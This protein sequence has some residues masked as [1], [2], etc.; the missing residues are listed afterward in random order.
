MAKPLERVP[1][2]LY[3]FGNASKPRPPR[4]QGHNLKPGQ[5][6]DIIPHEAG[7]VGPATFGG[8]SAFGEPAQA[9]LRGH[10]H[11]L[12]AGTELPEGLT[13]VADGIDVGGSHAPTHHTV[14][15][16]K[17]MSPQEFE[18]LFNNLPWQYGGK[19]S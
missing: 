3:A 11:V 7:Q 2:D 17:D 18:E 4:I 5:Q 6:P 13:V 12:P 19:T 10:Y 16:S 15:P 1:T 8:A 9:P 14:A